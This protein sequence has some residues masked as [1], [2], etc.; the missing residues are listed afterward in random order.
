MAR[1]NRPQTE[2]RLLDAAAALVT[3]EGLH[4]LGP[5]RVAD[6]AGCDKVLIYRY[7]GDIEKLCDAL[8]R[9]RILYPKPD[10]IITEAGLSVE[11]PAGDILAG[12]FRT[13]RDALARD[14]FARA[15]V[16]ARHTSTNPLVVHGLRQRA[17]F[18]QSLPGVLGAVGEGA[19]RALRLLGIAAESGDMAGS[20]LAAAAREAASHHVYRPTLRWEPGPGTAWPRHAAAS[21]EPD[22]PIPER[23][24]RKQS[25]R[26]QSGGKP[27][28]LDP[29]PATPESKPAATP[30]PVMDELPDNLL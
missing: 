12:F 27:R 1:R 19:G 20:D 22:L 23:P 9:K 8:A 14:P 16:A 7:F 26:K 24:A 3:R 21:T 13:M 25:A 4:A 11:S 30:A 28:H 18:A 17:E 29:R 5:N 15:L 10:A 2:Q 6:V